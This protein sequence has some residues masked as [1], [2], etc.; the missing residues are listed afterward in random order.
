MGNLSPRWVSGCAVLERLPLQPRDGA[1]ASSRTLLFFAAT[2]SITWLLLLPAAL[3]HFE[4]IPGPARRFALPAVLATFAPLSAALLV[5]RSEPTGIGCL[6]RQ[7]L[8]GRIG[9]GWYLVALATFPA[10]YVAGTG[11]YAL[12]GG[13]ARTWF[14]PPRNGQDIAAM[15]VVS[16]AE[17]PAW[18]GFALP[19][20]QERYGALRGSLLLGLAW[21]LYLASK[22]IVLGAME[23]SSVGTSWVVIPLS[24]ANIVAA[25]VVFCWLYDRTRGSLFIAILAHVGACVNNPYHALPGNITPFVVYTVAIGAAALAL[26]LGDRT[27]WRRSHTTPADDGVRAGRVHENPHPRERHGS[28]AG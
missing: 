26:V 15:F 24:L 28:I 5:A 12:L 11:A 14:Y 8:P 20:M 16:L 17:E 10:I 1:F 9:A 6:F 23:A 13:H 2:F 4:M 22:S 18:R 25:S 27:I 3:A 19:R 21:G 7:R